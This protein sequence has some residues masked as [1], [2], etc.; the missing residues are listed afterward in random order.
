M[1]SCFYVSAPA[2]APF[3]GA[4]RWDVAFPGSR[5]SVPPPE[6]NH[7]APIRGACLWKNGELTI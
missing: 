2:A 7:A 4:G 5:H 1:L 3:P 6:G